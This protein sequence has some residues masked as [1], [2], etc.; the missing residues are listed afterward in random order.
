MLNGK[1]KLTLF[2]VCNSICTC[3]GLPYRRFIL[4]VYYFN[5]ACK[6]S[7]SP[8]RLLVK[9]DK[10]DINDLHVRTTKVNKLLDAVEKAISIKP[11]NFFTFLNILDSIPLYKPIVEKARTMLS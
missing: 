7:Y 8:M 4:G 6:L 10:D 2:N 5:S 11:D 9:S 1:Y 3:T